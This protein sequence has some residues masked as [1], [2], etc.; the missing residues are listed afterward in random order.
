MFLPPARILRCSVW[1]AFM[2]HL[3]GCVP[4]LFVKLL[5]LPDEVWTL[6]VLFTSV[7]LSAWNWLYNLC[8]VDEAGCLQSS[9]LMLIVFTPTHIHTD[10]CSKTPSAHSYTQVWH[11]KYLGWYAHQW[12]FVIQSLIL[13]L[14]PKR[15][16]EMS[17]QTVEK[18]VHF[19]S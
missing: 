13:V 2:A 10:T 4:S 1:T 9:F 8:Q 3:L 18:R 11:L 17:W 14:S 6:C 16:W 7:C 15:Y 5:S 19:Y 12:A